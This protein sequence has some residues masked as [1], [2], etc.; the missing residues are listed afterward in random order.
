MQ[1]L[2]AIYRIEKGE[3]FSSGARKPHILN[4]LSLM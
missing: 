1:F 4:Y 2:L 3:M